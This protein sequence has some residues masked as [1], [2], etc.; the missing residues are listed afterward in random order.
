VWPTR[1]RYMWKIEELHR[2]YGMSES[3]ALFRNVMTTSLI[4]QLECH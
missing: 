1:Y 3:L 2:K 4:P